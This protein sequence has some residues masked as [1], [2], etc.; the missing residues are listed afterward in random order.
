MIKEIVSFCRAM[1]KTDGTTPMHRSQQAKTFGVH[2]GHE[3]TF[4]QFFL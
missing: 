2:D 1:R 3:N 4:L